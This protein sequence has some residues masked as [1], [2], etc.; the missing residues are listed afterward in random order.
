MFNNDRKRSNSSE[1]LKEKYNWW[2]S[3][4]VCLENNTNT[5]HIYTTNYSHFL[6]LNQTTWKLCIPHDTPNY[7]HTLHIQMH[8]ET[9]P[10]N[11]KTLDNAYVIINRG[12]NNM[13]HH[14][15]WIIQLLRYMLF[16]DFFPPVSFSVS[17]FI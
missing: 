4:N 8:Y 12:W 15:E 3:E 6:Q 17:T 2:Y 7:R 14:S 9:I 11:L 16:S 5:L 1:L 10:A 13:Y